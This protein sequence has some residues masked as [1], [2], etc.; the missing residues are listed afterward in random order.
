M[1]PESEYYHYQKM[2]G[3]AVYEHYILKVE[4]SILC[5][6]FNHEDWLFSESNF[7]GKFDKEVKNNKI[8]MKTQFEKIP[9]DAICELPPIIIAKLR[10]KNGL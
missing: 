6:T 7:S 1:Q 3:V 2:P 10:M 9:R 8:Y 5:L 4:G